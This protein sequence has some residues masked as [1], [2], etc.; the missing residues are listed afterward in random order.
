VTALVDAAMK[1]RGQWDV[2]FGVAFRRCPTELDMARCQ[3]EK[4]GDDHVSRLTTAWGDFDV[5]SDDEPKKPYR[6]RDELLGQLISFS[7]AP[8][9][10]VGSGAG[11][12]AY[13]LLG[14]ATPDVRRVA[15]INRGIRQ[16]LRADNAIDA[17]RIL[18][19][20]GTYNHKHGRPL[21]VE[22]LEVM[23]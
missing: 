9:L 1:Y 8:D 12:H 15:D 20:A 3:H 21:P 16:K 19:V 11:V 5:V 7:P 23:E 4:R 10:L 22:L 13:W 2:F 6:S 17:A 18:R 14:E